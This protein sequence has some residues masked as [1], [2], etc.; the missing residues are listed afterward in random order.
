MFLI[1]HWSKARDLL[2]CNSFNTCNSSRKRRT[3]PDWKC[4]RTVATRLTPFPSRGLE[5]LLCITTIRSVGKWLFPFFFDRWTHLFYPRFA[6]SLTRI[7][8]LVAWTSS[9]SSSRI[10]NLMPLL[11]QFCIDFDEEKETQNWITGC[12][13]KTIPLI[14]A[15]ESLGV[16]YIIFDREKSVQS[17]TSKI[18]RE[19]MYA[20][21]LRRR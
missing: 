14:R 11:W 21:T 18:V 20:E 5:T 15:A 3:F 10:F 9:K 7:S 19:S 12:C 4:C 13:K 16:I 2:T 1:I 17:V 6:L 8:I